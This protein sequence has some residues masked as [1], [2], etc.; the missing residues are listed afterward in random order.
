MSEAQRFAS[1]FDQ[2]VLH[3]F[4]LLQAMP[5]SAW[6]AIPVD[7]ETNYLGT[8]VNRITI[9]SLTKH[10]CAAEGHWLRRLGQIEEGSIVPPPGPSL[11]LDALQAGPK[12]L[13]HYARAHREHLLAAGSLT[14]VQLD[15]QFSFVGRKYSVRGFLWAIYGHHCYHVGQIDQLLRQQSVMPAEFLELTERERVI[16]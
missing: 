5:A 3:T 4:E 15:R 13:A 10:L 12:L 8:R 7:S 6:E 2:Q 11:E 14:P 16:A 1:L 9:S